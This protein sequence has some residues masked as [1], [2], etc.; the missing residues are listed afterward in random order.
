MGRNKR[1]RVRNGVIG[2]LDI[3]MM[4]PLKKKKSKKHSRDYFK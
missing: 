1:Y 2:Y 4:A 3:I